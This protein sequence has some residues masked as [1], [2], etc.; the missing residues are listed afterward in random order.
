[1]SVT[2]TQE[3]NYPC[4]MTNEHG[5]IVLM[6]RPKCGM[7]VEVGESNH[8][9]GD[10]LTFWCMDVFKPFEGEVRLSNDND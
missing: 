9:I 6:T 1:M 8:R 5:L 3:I 10:Y 7:V 2:E 4:I